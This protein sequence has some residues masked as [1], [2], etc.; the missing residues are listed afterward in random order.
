M[1]VL[2]VAL[3]SCAAMA[4]AVTPPPTSNTRGFPML[5]CYNCKVN[6]ISE[7]IITITNI[8]GISLAERFFSECN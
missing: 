6:M 1:T 3:E 8:A 2:Q 4:A 5:L 7:I